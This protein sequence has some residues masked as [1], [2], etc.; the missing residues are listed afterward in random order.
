MAHGHPNHN[1]FKC[2]LN[3]FISKMN[4]NMVS[5]GYEVSESDRACAGFSDWVCVCGEGDGG[6]GWGMLQDQ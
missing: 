6:G 2:I 4:A 5:S 3:A 1:V